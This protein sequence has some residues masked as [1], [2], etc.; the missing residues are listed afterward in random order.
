MVGAKGDHKFS[1]YHSTQMKKERDMFP[2][3]AET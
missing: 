2:D 1:Q 3:L